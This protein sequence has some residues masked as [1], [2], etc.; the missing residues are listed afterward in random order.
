MKR[1]HQNPFLPRVVFHGP[2][3][4]AALWHFTSPVM[5]AGASDSTI[6]SSGS[7]LQVM[8]GLGVVLAVI[9]GCAWLLKRMGGAYS[10]HAGVV[11][12]IGGSAVGQRERV[13]VVEVAETWLVIGVAPGHVT[14]LHNMPKG[15]GD[16]GAGM[17][18]ASGTP[19]HAEKDSNFSGWLKRLAEKHGG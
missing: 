18:H 1:K 15:K 14:V 3:S 16:M 5:A 13:V 2:L 19:G 4:A 10:G 17:L 11:R 7:P 9:A 12:I 8:L 6:A